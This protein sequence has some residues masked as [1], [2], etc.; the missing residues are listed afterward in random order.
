[1]WLVA[2]IVSSITLVTLFSV[3]G[4]MLTAVMVTLLLQSRLVFT[5]PSGR[6]ADGPAHERSARAVYA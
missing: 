1:M 6:P 4:L 2:V 3:G 5:N